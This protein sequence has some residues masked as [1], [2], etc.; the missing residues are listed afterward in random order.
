MDFTGAVE[1]RRKEIFTLL[2]KM[3]RGLIAV[4]LSAG[5]ILAALCAICPHLP[6]ESRYKR[7]MMP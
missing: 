7:R 4:T 6:A 3:R 2:S 1:P 5:L